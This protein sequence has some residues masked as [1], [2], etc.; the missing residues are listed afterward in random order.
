LDSSIHKRFP[1]A[2]GDRL[3]GLALLLPSA[4]ML[5]I[6]AF[7][8][9]NPSGLGTHRA[10][11]L[12]SCTFL[13]LTGW[14]CPTCGMTTT[15]ALAMH[16]HVG[17]ALLNQPFGFVLWLC[18]VLGAA[19]GLGDLVL[20]RGLL[21]K[22][23]DRVLEPYEGWLAGGILVGLLAGWLYKLLAWRVAWPHP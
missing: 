6:A 19:A 5:T 20:A 10:M 14:P 22:L 3:I 17:Q 9:P 4:T 18:T 7:L 16:G 8:P 13:S 1:R 21:R 2:L 15:F 12:G 11:G 23:W